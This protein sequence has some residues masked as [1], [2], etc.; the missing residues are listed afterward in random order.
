MMIG[1]EKKGMMIDAIYFMMIDV[2]YFMM[3]C[4]YL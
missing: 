3:M 4:N 1:K 2:I